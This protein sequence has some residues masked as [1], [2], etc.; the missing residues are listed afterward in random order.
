MK[1]INK[2]VYTKSQVTF[3]DLGNASDLPSM[4]SKHNTQ[5]AA[6]LKDASFSLM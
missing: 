1:N 2:S 4:L 6:A 5:M 3:S